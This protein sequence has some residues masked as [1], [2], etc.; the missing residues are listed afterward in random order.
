MASTERTQTDT[1]GDAANA[2]AIRTETTK[3]IVPEAN[4]D[5]KSTFATDSYQ[6]GIIG[7]LQHDTQHDPELHE[8][9]SKSTRDENGTESAHSDVKNGKNGSCSTLWV[10]DIS[11]AWKE[12][13]IREQFKSYGNILDI[14]IIRSLY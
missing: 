11:P 4:S 6:D 5:K 10:G 13:F 1:V 14:K 8:K 3:V 12:D 9:M 7:D 2:E